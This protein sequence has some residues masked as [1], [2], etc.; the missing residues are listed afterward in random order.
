MSLGNQSDVI[1]KLGWCH[2]QLHNLLQLHLLLT[3]D[4]IWPHQEF[5]VNFW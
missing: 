2:L 3:S 5:I 4:L 1:L